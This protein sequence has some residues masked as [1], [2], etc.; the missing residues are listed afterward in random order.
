M[1]VQ[2]PQNWGNEELMAR[3]VM[4]EPRSWSQWLVDKLWGRT[5]S[6]QFTSGFTSLP[7]LRI[8]VLPGMERTA[9]RLTREGLRGPWFHGTPASPGQMG[10]LEGLLRS[11]FDPQKMGKTAGIRLGEPTGVSLTRS[12]RVAGSFGDVLRVGV[13]VP[14]SAVGQFVDPEFQRLL[15]GSYEGAL[16]RYKA[17]HDA[18]STMLDWLKS[19]PG[20][21]PYIQERL[22]GE[23]SAFNQAMS[24]H[25]RNQ[26]VEAIAYSPRRWSEFE[27]RV[28]DPSKAVPLGRIPPAEIGG[29]LTNPVMR[30]YWE[31]VPGAG[32]YAGLRARLEQAFHEAP[33]FP[34][35][36]RDILNVGAD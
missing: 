13:D 6:E 10:Q 23:F 31:G 19:D 20:A 25:L 1:A 29:T 28:L 32:P 15:R 33:T 8:G 35:R 11:G 12:P 24:D 22:R 34:A 2:L 16:S 36:L 30:R 7:M 26:G 4:D 9:S 27:L 18:T 14:P 17:G 5:P 21:L 3:S